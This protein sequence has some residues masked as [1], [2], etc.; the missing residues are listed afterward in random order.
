M[1]KSTSKVDLLFMINDLKETGDIDNAMRLQK[2]FLDSI[3]SDREAGKYTIEIELNRK[4][5][6][7]FSGAKTA[8]T[9]QSS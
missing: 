8:L 9:S 6:K 7:A 2:I 1:S 4:E 5:K 3:A